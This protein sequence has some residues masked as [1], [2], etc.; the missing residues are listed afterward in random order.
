MIL[1]AWT[2]LRPKESRSG[3]LLFSGA[4]TRLVLCS[5][6]PCYNFRPRKPESHPL[7]IDTHS[8]NFIRYASRKKPLGYVATIGRQSLAIPALYAKYGRFCEGFL[9]DHF[10]A[11]R[12]DSY[13]NSDYEGATHIADLNKALVPANQYDT[14]LDFGTTEHIYNIPQALENIS[15]LCADGGQILH[16]SPANNF[17]GHGF[18][19]Y[20]PELFFSLYSERN[21]C[22]D[23]EVFLADLNR[24]RYWFEVLRPSDGSRAQATSTSPLYVLCRTVK[25]RTT[26]HNDIQQSD[27]VHAWTK[28]P[29]AADQNGIRR[30]LK[31][32]VKK[33]PVIYRIL[34]SLREYRRTK[35]ER[36]GLSHRNRHLK[37]V[38]VAE[39]LKS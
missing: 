13:D 7:G 24:I 19:Q 34:L 32:L 33:S 17:C 28:K 31:A 23:T 22:G 38:S 39:L 12:V 15:L 1:A 37:K 10:G 4:K 18:W 27:Y 16:V 9:I 6:F 25:R 2:H 5:R 21:G 3:C 20:S 14:V 11:T 8:L 30:R 35:L 29:Q 36:I 26:A